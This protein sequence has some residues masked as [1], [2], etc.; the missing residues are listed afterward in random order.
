[1]GIVALVAAAQRRRHGT[2]ALQA[3]NLTPAEES[4]LAELLR[5]GS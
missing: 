1:V 3:E 4:R 2:A 5:E